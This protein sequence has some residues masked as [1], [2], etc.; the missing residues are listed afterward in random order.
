MEIK[1][2]IIAAAGSLLVAFVSLATSLL[3]NKQSKKTQ[4]SIERLRFDLSKEE[5]REKIIE[6]DK[7]TTLAALG[8]AIQHM[9]EVKD[10]LQLILTA[11][12]RSLDSKS[13][14]EKMAAARAGLFSCYEGQ[15]SVLSGREQS[16]VHKAKNIAL[17]MDTNLKKYAGRKRYVAAFTNDQKDELLGLRQSL[18]E[19]QDLLRDSRTNRIYGTGN[20][21]EQ[22]KS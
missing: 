13:A 16:L 1:L 5:S 18:T 21:H 8:S 4:E 22:A 7:V 20:S 19:I 9:A 14:L 11:P 15:C 6:D 3:S 2:A 10:V 17:V 12:R